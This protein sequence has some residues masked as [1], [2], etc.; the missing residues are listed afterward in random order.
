M[1]ILFDLQAAQTNGLFRRGVGNYSQGLF[2]TFA[3]RNP[4]ADT[5]A[6]T[7]KWL[8]NPLDLT[9]VSNDRILTLEDKPCISEA[10]DFNG[11]N[12]DSLEALYHS[13]VCQSINPDVVHVSHNFLDCTDEVL[14]PRS[15]ERAAGQILSCTLYD[16]IPLVFNEHYLADEQLKRRY[17]FQLQHLRRFDI[18]FAISESTKQDAIDLLGIDPSKI[19]TIHGGTGRAFDQKI[20]REQS[21]A[22]IRSKFRLKD[23]ILM[24]TGGD[25]FRKNIAGAIESFAKIDRELRLRSSF[26]IVGKISPQS[27][28]HLLNIAKKNGL[29][30]GDIIFTGFVDEATLVAFYQACDGFVFPSMYE[31]LGLPVLEAMKCGAPVIGSNNSSIGEIINHKDALFDLDQ[32]GSMPKRI[33]Q[34]L[35]DQQYSDHLRDHGLKRSK[36]FSWSKTA[37]LFNDAL[38]QKQ[39]EL[40]TQGVSLAVSGYLARKRIAILTPIPPSQ[41]GIADYCADFLPYL[42]KHFEID[43]FVNQE[44]CSDIQVSSTF[45]VFHIQE[46]TS[47][48]KKYDTILYEIGN[49][50]FHTHMLP[51][52]EQYPGVVTLHDAYMSGILAHLEFSL[53]HQNGYQQELLY[54]HGPRGRRF[55]SPTTDN[56]ELVAKAIDQ[57][58]T[59]K[60]ILD[61]AIGIISHST[62]NLDIAN[63]HYPEGW[64]AP[65][66]VIP[67]LIRSAPVSNTAETSARVKLG[68]PENAFVISTFGH[69]V[70]TK[71]GDLLLD[72]FLTSPILNQENVY[73]IFVGKPSNDD[74]GRSLKKRIKKSNAQERIKIT[75]FVSN[76]KYKQ[77]L[78]AS[79]LA[80]QLRT[81]SRG[82]TPRSVLDCLAN[83]LPVILNDYASFKDYDNDVVAKIGGEICTT[84]LRNQLETLFSN[85]ERRTEFAKAGLEYVKN[86]HD[87]E[88]C[89]AMYANAIHEFIER[90]KVNTQDHLKDSIAPYVCND[91]AA[92]F[93]KGVVE[94]T[95]RFN[96]CR[97][98]IFIDV[99]HIAQKD[100]QTGIQRI[101]RDVVASMYTTEVAG[102]EPIAV[103]LINGQMRPASH[104]LNEHNLLSSYERQ[105]PDQRPIQFSKGDILLMLD[106]SWDMYDEF[107]PVFEQ[108]RRNH[109]PVV[110]VIYDLLPIRI[111]EYFVEGGPEWFANWFSKAVE[112]C[113]AFV[114]ISKATHDDVLEYYK[115]NDTRNPPKVGYWHHGSNF[116]AHE[117]TKKASTLPKQLIEQKYLLMVG[118]IEPRK[119]H[120]LAIEAMKKLWDDGIDLKLCIAGKQGWMVEHLMESIREL[121]H[122]TENFV[123]CESPTDEALQQL[124][125]NASGML[126][127]SKGEGLGLPLIEAAK[128]KIPIICSD[129]PSFRELASQHATFTEAPS[130][131]QLSLDIRKWVK[132]EKSGALPDSSQIKIQDCDQSTTALIKT[133]IE[134]LNL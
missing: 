110:N 86:T 20:D 44:Q 31:G 79:N 129:I 32:S 103:E 33:E 49:S 62:Y 6:L 47:V 80:V 54:S 72:A 67:Q 130:A 83:E 90:S 76:Q 37:D 17:L 122:S 58:P 24:Y 77:Y 29:T 70:W 26:V 78:R 75:G 131:T 48:A 3:E 10:G 95:E 84:E 96:F 91:N 41:S 11:G 109:V 4:L 124:Y 18:L 2:E 97:R 65:Y 40:Q 107:T 93:T 34:V 63:Q 102:I 12:R 128:H 27:Q 99:S 132:L 69:V 117:T 25:D 22:L 100:H 73:L 104:W 125:A 38:Q 68:I 115:T 121:N 16:L 39:E 127:L 28:A 89:A 7:S 23:K 19:V 126:C 82:G 50:D 85:R 56:R 30:Q 113:D 53:N 61:H 88:K 81:N 60:R 42:S 92:K 116:I 5:F 134:T 21:A 111:P 45:R 98:K 57:L 43:V 14:L 55:I 105:F 64:L 101:V 114:C 9:C 8:P 36:E 108:A 133:L 120:E 74:F 71:R 35:E 59:T 15:I 118:T 112:Q 66:R 51:L 87:P 106:S 119:L 1:R 123:F 94:S 46:F 52:L 13:S